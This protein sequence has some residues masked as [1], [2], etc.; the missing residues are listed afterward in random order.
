MSLP[1][2]SFGMKR[3]PA[4]RRQPFSTQNTC[5]MRHCWRR[6]IAQMKIWCNVTNGDTRIV[7]C[8]CWIACICVSSVS[9]AGGLECG[10]APVYWHQAACAIRAAAVY[11]LR[12][13]GLHVRSKPTCHLCITPDGVTSRIRHQFLIEQSSQPCVQAPVPPSSNTFEVLRFLRMEQ[14]VGVS[15][16]NHIGVAK[17][18][19]NNMLER[20]A[21]VSNH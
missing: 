17:H 21:L 12:Q 8:R 13:S 5:L 1:A 10:S 3:L 2:K 6:L 19:H 16:V 11:L 18:E 4:D 14:M 9:E 20:A 7:Y 15:W